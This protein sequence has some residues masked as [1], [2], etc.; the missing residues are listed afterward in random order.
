MCII[1][2]YL[3]PL[4]NVKGPKQPIFTIATS[5][6]SLNMYCQSLSWPLMGRFN[7]DPTNCWKVTCSL[8]DMS[9]TLSTG[10]ILFPAA[11]L[12]LY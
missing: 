10:E 1:K 4:I 9:I 5:K 11:P 7:C 2:P 8:S 6:N 12:L 3:Y